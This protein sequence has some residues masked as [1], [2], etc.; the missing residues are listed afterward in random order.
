MEKAD[1]VSP[2]A[3]V[4]M[5]CQVSMPQ[6]APNLSRFGSE[7]TS[8]TPPPMNER[9]AKARRRQKELEDTNPV[10]VVQWKADGNPSNNTR[11]I[12]TPYCSLLQGLK[13]A[14]VQYRLDTCVDYTFM[15]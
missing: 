7:S 9:E 2:T 6:A 4:L 3:Y 8:A 5:Y 15:T 1:V 10:V 11:Y 13:R 12:L 14:Q